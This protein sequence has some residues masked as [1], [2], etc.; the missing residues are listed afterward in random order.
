MFIVMAYATPGV[1][2]STIQNA[3]QAED[4]IASGQSPSIQ[5]V[6]SIEQL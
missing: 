4:A 3:V 1:E 5:G 2:L 6:A